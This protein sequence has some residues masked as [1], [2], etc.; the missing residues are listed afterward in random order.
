MNKIDSQL[1]RKI[2][3][4]LFSDI[5]KDNLENFEKILNLHPSL[6][7][8]KNK[9]KENI[10]FYAFEKNAK[11][12]IDFILSKNPDLL[13]EKNIIGLTVFQDLIIKNKDIAYFLSKF[14]NLSDIEKMEF[15][16]SHDPNGNNI[17]FFS[18]QNNDIKQLKTLIE[19][20]PN[21][22]AIQEHQNEYGQNL[23][24][25]LA[26]NVSQNIKELKNFIS[27]EL[28]KK[29][30]FLTGYT[31]VMIAASNQTKENFEILFNFID[32]EQ[33]SYN[34]NHLFHLAASN[35]I[36]IIN[37]LN[38]KN[39]KTNKKNKLGQSALGISISKNKLDITENIFNL[40]KDEI[41]YAEDVVAITKISSKNKQL[42]IKIIENSNNQFLNE[43][44]K[45]KFLE[46]LFLH[47]EWATIENIK[48]T[49][50]FKGWFI[51]KDFGIL[52]A[53]T[54]AGRKDMQKKIDFL[55]QEKNIL[56]TK[57]SIAVAFAINTLPRNQIVYVLEKTSLLQKIK[58]EDKTLIASVFLE[59]NI[60][61]SNLKIKM[62]ESS[63]VQTIIKGNLK[64]SKIH[65]EEQIT[66]IN[67][68]LS[69]IKDENSV[70]KH[71][72]KL[73]S[74][75]KNPF[76][77][78]EKNKKTLTKEK[79]KKLIFYT[80]T[81]II[82]NEAPISQEIKEIVSN[83]Q[84]LLKSVIDGII[85]YNKVPQNKEIIKLIKDK[86]FI[87]QDSLINLLNKNKN[88]EQVANF[89]S[90]HFNLFNLQNIDENLIVSIGNH[91]KG[92]M[93]FEAILKHKKG[94]EDIF[95]SNYLDLVGQEKI[96]NFNQEF[97]D[98]KTHKTKKIKEAIEK[99]FF[100]IIEN[101]E[102]VNTDFLHDLWNLS[103]STI[104][105]VSIFS[106]KL[107]EEQKFKQINNLQKSIKKHF[108]F[109]ELDLSSTDLMS[110]H[111]SILINDNTHKDFF[112][113]LYQNKNDIHFKQVNDFL[114]KFKNDSKENNISVGILGNFLNSVDISVIKKSD[115]NLI[116]ETLK[117]GITKYDNLDFISKSI[118]ED[119]F[120]LLC[121]SITRLPVDV[122]IN[123]K[124]SGIFEI[125]DDETQITINKEVLDYKLDN[126]PI[127]KQEKK[128][129][130]I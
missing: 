16:K 46:G 126:K 68:W 88:F 33:I 24:H 90:D 123:I 100:S 87:E 6:I 41:I 43:E 62:N 55:I 77:F 27:P 113:L 65:L 67:E 76:D 83:Y 35:N 122:L 103:E 58:E 78:I 114:Y 44:Q 69:I 28:M 96:K 124:N 70:F 118:E 40:F 80:I 52:F 36:E 7:N 64:N 4:N 97:L 57:E 94:S 34:G 26:I 37:F 105:E 109:K 23:G 121:K 38:D 75:L 73:I 11:N 20:C 2:I 15:Y 71:Y 42:F 112:D 61:I 116:F 48:T 25:F 82:K 117:D 79:Q 115:Q 119:N 95:I 53:K 60:D 17:F 54:V 110:L 10:L 22:K 125:L 18:T 32:A 49:E 127:V 92:S 120:E 29:Q 74:N 30:D 91:P 39:L 1:N 3:S 47:A 45:Q 98:I 130:K 129:F 9:K 14:S 106:N 8:F 31:P 59:R 93:V 56:S 66:K 51:E 81:S 107:F 12:I 72:G 63:A 21:F 104:E 50:K 13:K 5:K 85:K 111:S 84:M 86:N 128:K 101:H 108:Q 19:N 102:K 89:V 99:N